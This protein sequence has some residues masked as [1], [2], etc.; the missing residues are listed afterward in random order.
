MGIKPLFIFEMANNH[1]GK[2]DRG[3]EI[4]SE[5]KKQVESYRDIFDFAFKLQYR[6]LDT[7]I[8]PDYKEKKDLNF[9]KRFNDTR[10]SLEDFFLLKNKFIEQGFISICT[11]FDEVSVD[12]IEKQK[13][14]IIKIASCSFNDWP[15]LEK[16]ETKNLH[17]IASTAGVSLEDID[18][19]VQFFT[20]R[21]KNISLMHCVAEY[22]TKIENLQLNQ[23]DI[24]KKRY[25]NI[26]IGYSTHENPNDYESI[27]VAIAKGAKIFEKHV[28]LA[29]YDGSINKYSATPEQIG[30]WLKTAKETFKYCGVENIRYDF[31]KDEIES[32]KGL[33]RCV[34]A[35][36]DIKIGE[37]LD[38]LNTFYAIPSI[39]GQLF[40]F[41]LSKYKEFTALN[42]I[43]KNEPIMIKDLKIVDIRDKVENIINKIKE[44]LDNARIILPNKVSFELSHHYGFENFN[45]VGAVIINCVNR[46]Y[47]KKII[48]ML[49]GQKHPAHKHKIKEETFQVLYGDITISVDGKTEDLKAGDIKLVNRESMHSFL[50]HNGV[51]FEEISTQHILNDSYYE[52][53]KVATNN[54]RK[55]K[56]TYWRDN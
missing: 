23:I 21:E 13:Y 12:L 45:E 48:V 18:K 24:L 8:H 46:E 54:K 20:H 14:D 3:I 40:N 34:F 43:K 33:S 32:L 4:V 5:I 41:D 38:N 53:E 39:E 7:F 42:N 2:L 50:T 51:I 31:P 30:K 19:V 17:I 49:P 56:F 36:K 16:I 55:T 15:L 10:L 6:N 44:M 25:P 11:P 22:P 52:D 37:V 27:K 9:V 47:C 1:N 29:D 26:T 35:S 28:G